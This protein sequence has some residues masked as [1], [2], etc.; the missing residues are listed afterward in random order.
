MRSVIGF[1]GYRR[2]VRLAANASMAVRD[3]LMTMANASNAV[4]YVGKTRL[5]I[6][7]KTLIFWW[8][9]ISNGIC[10]GTTVK[11]WSRLNH[12]IPVMFNTINFNS[13]AK[14]N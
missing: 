14:A 10:S 9:I 7:P 5:A 6:V 11:S 4:A 3:Y 2:W 1:L 12:S 8:V 13:S